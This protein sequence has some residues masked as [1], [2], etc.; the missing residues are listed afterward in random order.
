MFHHQGR[1]GE[2]TYFED[3]GNRFSR[4]IGTDLPVYMV[5]HG[6]P[7]WCSGQSSWLQIQRSGFESRRYQIFWEVVGLQRGSLS[8]ASTT[9]ELLGR[10][11][12]GSS[13]ESR[14]YGRRDPLRWLRGPLY[15]RKLALTSQTTGGCS[16]DTVHSRTQATESVM[17][18][19]LRRQ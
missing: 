15:A 6:R 13:I 14:E 19:H 8:L 17:V 9:D 1:R 4:K 2:K 10:K 16:V 5:S 18:S 11:S 12:G 3:R 7:L